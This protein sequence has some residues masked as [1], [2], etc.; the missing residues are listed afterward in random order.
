MYVYAYFFAVCYLVGNLNNLLIG[1]LR[2][3]FEMGAAIF[4]QASS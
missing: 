3:A 2:D 1:V 4:F